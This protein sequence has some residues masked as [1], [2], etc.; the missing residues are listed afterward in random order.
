MANKHMYDPH[1]RLG[2]GITPSTKL[3]FTNTITTA[4]E[5]DI[6]DVWNL[7]KFHQYELPFKDSVL[8]LLRNPRNVNAINLLHTVEVPKTWPACNHEVD[9]TVKLEEVTGYVCIT[10]I[11]GPTKTNQ[12]RLKIPLLVHSTSI[13]A[14][15]LA[16][17]IY[18]CLYQ[19]IITKI[20]TDIP[21]KLEV[22]L[23]TSPHEVPLI[24]VVVGF[25]SL[26]FQ[27]AYSPIQVPEVGHEITVPEGNKEIGITPKQPITKGV[28]MRQRRN[29]NTPEVI[30]EVR[31]TLTFPR[32][33][34]LP[35]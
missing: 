11:H 14:E 23:W 1:N 16:S 19:Y 29:L 18:E 21:T 34:A 5:E 17:L 24:K 3:A 15:Q 25:I 27:D 20:Y 28:L 22:T 7:C 6:H 31:H 8:H 10:P 2:M 26:L 9:G 30:H 32:L 4:G 12:I 33:P 13:S 35:K